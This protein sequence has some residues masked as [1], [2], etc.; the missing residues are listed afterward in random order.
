MLVIIRSLTMA[1]VSRYHD[2][3]F[4]LLCIV[5]FFLGVDAC[6]LGAH[7]GI[8][9]D[10]LV[11]W[12]CLTILQSASHVPGLSNLQR[13][14]LCARFTRQWLINFLKYHLI[15]RKFEKPFFLLI[16]MYDLT[17]SGLD[18]PVWLFGFILIILVLIRWH[19]WL[20][21]SLQA[22]V[23]HLSIIWFSLRTSDLLWFLY[24]YKQVL[25]V[26]DCWC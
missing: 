8:P 26:I 6:E 15:H 16:W 5:L 9:L 21:N 4:N 19:L 7:T 11:V 3:L 12:K 18:F 1:S 14:G 13:E 17:I 25:R 10:V 22:S 20:F 24:F 23:F 2:I